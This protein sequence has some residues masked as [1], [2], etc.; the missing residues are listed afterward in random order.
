[1]MMA[2]AEFVSR[3]L[4]EPV[5]LLIATNPVTGCW[6]LLEI[7]ERELK[8]RDITMEDGMKHITLIDNPQMMNDEDMNILYNAADVGLNTCQ[9]E[10]WGMTNFELGAIGKG[11]I[12][13]G[14]GGL[15][16]FFDKDSAIQLKPIINLYT[17]TSSDGAPGE[18]QICHPNDYVEAMETYYAN[19]DILE[20]H[21]KNA[22]KNILAKYQWSD[23]GKILYDAILKVADVTETIELTD[24]DVIDIIET[25]V[26]PDKKKEEK[27][28]QIKKI[29]NIKER[30]QAKL[31]AKKKLKESA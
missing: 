26:I 13:P 25:T 10:G 14:I 21:G 17:D 23:I 28:V 15:L 19:K 12:V 24:E 3:H 6:N 11:N 2:W 5:K 7:Y 4:K 27:P 16:D 1:M 29:T 8:K 30:L 31:A 20:K 9:G 18:C 22:R